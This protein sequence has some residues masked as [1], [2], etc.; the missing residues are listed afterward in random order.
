[1]FKVGDQ[2]K[3]VRRIYSYSFYIWKPEMDTYIG[4]VYTITEIN[5]IG[6]ES[7]YTLNTKIKFVFCKE[8]LESAR[9]LKLKRV[10]CL[11]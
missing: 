1:M 5:L 9:K 4:N 3:V 11:K 2:V 7:F 8:S 10:L 6:N